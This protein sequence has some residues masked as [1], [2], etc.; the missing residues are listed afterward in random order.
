[1]TRSWCRW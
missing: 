1:M